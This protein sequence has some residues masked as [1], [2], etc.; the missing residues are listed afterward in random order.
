VWWEGDNARG[1]RPH[2]GGF[3]KNVFLKFLNTFTKQQK[4]IAMFTWRVY[5]YFSCTSTVAWHG[6][7]V[8]R[9]S[10]LWINPPNVFLSSLSEHQS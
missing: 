9:P 5:A 1:S 8:T 3:A 6:N 4:S 10:R 2:E 7:K